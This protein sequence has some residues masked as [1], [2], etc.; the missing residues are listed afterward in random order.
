[1]GAVL[2][3]VHA[4]CKAGSVSGVHALEGVKHGEIHLH[5]QFRLEK[6]YNTERWQKA[7]RKVLAGI[8]LRGNSMDG[9]PEQ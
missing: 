6:N 4:V 2:V 7:K 8:A 1:M 5:M 9:R 3:P